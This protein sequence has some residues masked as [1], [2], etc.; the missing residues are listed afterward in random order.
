MKKRDEK[1][2]IRNFG[3]FLAVLMGAIGALS[4]YKQG[5]AWPYLW[6]IGGYS[7]ITCLFIKPALKPVF[8]GAM[9]LGMKLN[10]VMTR[11]ILTI[12]FFLVVTPF[13]LVIQLFRGDL[14]KRKYDP[15]AK[16]YWQPTKRPNYEPEQTERLF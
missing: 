11:V 7:L 9:W 1:K 8:T 5:G 16:T 2:D 4:F 12:F 14:L 10:W 13:A 6:A 3:L 15:N